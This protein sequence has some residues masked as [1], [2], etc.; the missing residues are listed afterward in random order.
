MSRKPNW[1]RKA[2][3]Q[4]DRDGIRTLSRGERS[5]TKQCGEPA[6]RKR[7]LYHVADVGNRCFEHAIA[8][9]GRGA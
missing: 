6:C 2:A 9:K 3:E 1:T 8:F 7:P 4:M 5:P